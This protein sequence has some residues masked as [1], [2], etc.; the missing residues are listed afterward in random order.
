MLIMIQ[1]FEIWTNDD[2]SEFAAKLS[3]NS[4]FI[5]KTNLNS[6]YSRLLYAAPFVENNVNGLAHIIDA[7]LRE[8][9]RSYSELSHLKN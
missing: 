7:M 3:G 4:K 6:T 1:M 8:M 2:A 9:D 5:I